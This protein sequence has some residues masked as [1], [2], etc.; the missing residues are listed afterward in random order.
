MTWKVGVVGDDGVE[1][2]SY[3]FLVSILWEWGGGD[4]G[5]FRY[6]GI[7]LGGWPGGR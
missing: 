5:N 3:G 7:G 4:G 1:G 6:W 2:M